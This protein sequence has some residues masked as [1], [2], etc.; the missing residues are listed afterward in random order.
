VA[1]VVALTHALELFRYGII[2]TS[3]V[4]APHNIW[5]PEIATLMAALSMLVLVV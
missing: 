3:G 5:G 4:W 2:G 1:K